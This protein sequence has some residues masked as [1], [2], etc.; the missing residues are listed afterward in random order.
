MKT[1][2]IFLLV[3]KSSSGK[4]AIL[5]EMA[6]QLSLKVALSFTTRPKREGEVNLKDYEF[7]TKEDFQ[8]KLI[9]NEI[10]ESVHYDVINTNG[11]SD[12]WYYGLSSSQLLQE[13]YVIAI[14]NP[15]G[16]ETLESIPYIKDKLVSILIDTPCDKTRLLRA[17][18]RE[19]MTNEKVMEVCRRALADDKDLKDVYC[20][21][22]V[23]NNGTLDKCFR[24]TRRIIAEEMMRGDL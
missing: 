20:D 4:N 23:Y 6:K 17:F 7:I 2:K 8:H 16:K 9:N 13:G 21:Y 14:V 12:K 19:N 5:D 3:G 18:D 24:D 11:K 22:V 15:Y 10:I 1:K